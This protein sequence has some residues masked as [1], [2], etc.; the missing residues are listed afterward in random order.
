VERVV[1]AAARH[2]IATLTLYA[3]SS[4][5]WQRP[6]AEVRALFSL[7]RRYLFTQTQRCLEHSIRINVIGRR[8]RIEPALVSAISQSEQITAQCRGMQLRLAIDYSSQFTILEASRRHASGPGATREEFL[9]AL[10]KTDHSNPPAAPVD[11]LI[12][13]GGEKRL[14]DFMLWECAYSELHFV[15]TLWPDFD[16]AAF[17]DALIEYGRRSRRFGRI[18]TAG[19]AEV[20]HA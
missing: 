3:F 8:D 4:D 17:G 15:D 1:T 9:D 20:D 19:V 6:P 5:N 18:D 2:N 14:S 10:S 16:E 11:L 7:L 13:T 12:R